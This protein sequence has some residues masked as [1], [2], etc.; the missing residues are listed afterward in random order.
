MSKEKNFELARLK[1]KELIQ[2]DAVIRVFKKCLYSTSDPFEKALN[3]LPI[4]NI[5]EAKWVDETV[6]VFGK[7]AEI[8]HTFC[9]NCN[10]DT[11]DLTRF[12]PECGA[13]MLNPSE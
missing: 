5:I 9:S 6:A 2:K 4:F 12:C 7:G 11:R 10:N 3:E 13:K 8:C 1:T